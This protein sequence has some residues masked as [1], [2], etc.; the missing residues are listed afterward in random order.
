M[1]R[2]ID[3]DLDS[4][5]T[6]FRVHDDAYDA[7]SRYLDE[8]RARLA[9]DPDAA[10]VTGDLERSIAAKLTDRIGPAGRIVTLQDI[11][12]VLADVGPVGTGDE[13]PAAPPP[14]AFSDRPHRRRRLYRIRDG[15]Q[16]AGVCTG[17]AAYTEIDVAWIRTIFI[18]ATLVTA[19]AFLIVYLVLAFVLPVAP[20][21]DAWVAAQD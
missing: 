12:A 11:E 1:H 2:V 3:I 15:Q 18:F 17:L 20:T 14:P 19:G 21:Y 13:R 5:P 16:F 10:E 8:A 7:L 6:P 9:D 4:H